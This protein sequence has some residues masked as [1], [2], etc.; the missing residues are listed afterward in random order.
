MIFSFI[1]LSGLLQVSGA[2]DLVLYET[3][4]LP[5]AIATKASKADKAV[6]PRAQAKAE[7]LAGHFDVCLQRLAGPA[8]KQPG[9]GAW[10]WRQKLICALPL[11]P[12][13]KVKRAQIFE[14]LDGVN[15]HTWEWSRPPYQES[16]RAKWKDL[17]LANM[18]ATS[19]WPPGD[20]KR[21]AEMGLR[22]KSIFSTS[23]R[24]KLMRLM[25]E[26]YLAKQNFKLARQWM[27]RALLLEDSQE[28]RSRIDVVDRMSKEPGADPVSNLG[29]SKKDIDS[30]GEELPKEKELYDRILQTQKLGDLIGVAEDLISILEI[31]PAGVRSK[32][33]TEKLQEIYT[34]VNE[35]EDSKFQLAKGRL[36]SVLKKV[37]TLKL[38][39]WVQVAFRAG[40]YSDSYELGQ[41]VLGR[42]EP[43]TAPTK[44]L[45]L[46]ARSAQFIGKF[47]E[48]RKLFAEVITTHA[49]SEEVLDGYQQLAFMDM[50]EGKYPSAIGF[51]EK[52]LSKPRESSVE[53]TARYWLWRALEKTDV[54]RAGFE[55]KTLVEKFPLSYYGLRARLETGG[56]P[57]TSFGPALTDKEKKAKE[58]D[59]TEIDRNVFSESEKESLDRAEALLKD[60]WLE[61]AKLELSELT[62]PRAIQA[63]VWLAQKVSSTA[64]F[65][66]AS[67]IMNSVWEED[68]S[69]V[70]EA[71]MKIVFPRLFLSAL[72]PEAKRYKLENLLPLSLMRQES[73][74]NVRAVSSS[75]ALG[76]MQMIPPTAKDTAKELNFK[77]LNLP[78]DLFDPKTN[79]KFCV[80]Y[81]S[82]VILEFDGNIPA[83]LAAYNAGPTR[84]RKWMKARK[85]VLVPSSDPKEEMWFDELPWDETRFYVK[86]ILRNLFIYRYLDR[87]RVSMT[88][89]LWGPQ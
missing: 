64:D 24:A 46:T 19:F 48:A 50:R 20:R 14:L 26:S 47:D 53:L 71:M 68:V 70:N 22:W 83:G 31:A 39:K 55:A 37:D 61:E 87:G 40:Q 81:L 56:G 23:E 2:A 41:E 28:T 59:L 36:M 79:M 60:G 16:L 3:G 6:T 75:G 13:E 82:K 89:P 17:L 44:T 33:A 85:L 38:A 78:D 7:Y 43:M 73:G 34:Q 76:L 9:I 18:D 52:I 4:I 49:A 30:M 29:R 67:M 62:E 12:G 10:V 15:Q 54:V 65:L 84:L 80:Y 27:E 69:Y 74:F 57:I 42:V 35:R 58:R 45:W 8:S 21:L 77:N 32:W 63:R 51:L 25:G 66:R 88:Q 72:D 1:F 86:A 5:Q 11:L